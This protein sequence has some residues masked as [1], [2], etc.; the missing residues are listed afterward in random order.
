[1][2]LIKT[3]EIQW[4]MIM[5]IRTSATLVVFSLE[6]QYRNSWITSGTSSLDRSTSKIF[7][8]SPKIL[9]HCPLEVNILIATVVART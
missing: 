5:M 3:K 7:D 1:M 8:S 4:S 2:L 6:N 9:M